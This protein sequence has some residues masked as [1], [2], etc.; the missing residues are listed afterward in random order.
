MNR[1]N[2]ASAIGLQLRALRKRQHLTQ[3]GVARLARSAGLAWVPNTVSAV[4]Q[5][6]RALTLEEFLLLPL[7]FRVPISELL[8]NA[9]MLQMTPEAAMGS[10][11]LRMLLRGESPSTIPLGELDLPGLRQLPDR[12]PM[13][14]DQM[15]ATIKANRWVWPDATDWDFV[16]AGH[17]S[18]GE[19]EKKAAKRLG[20]SRLV[21]ALAARRKWGHSLTEERDCRVLERADPNSS[22]RSLQALRGLVTRELLTEIEPITRRKK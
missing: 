18:E 21:V 14:I 20:V 9:A 4:E 5:G 10:D 8:P 19:A 7:V 3:D 11:G 6:R 17:D 22:A 1:V 15:K 2:L 12:I 13:A 16:E